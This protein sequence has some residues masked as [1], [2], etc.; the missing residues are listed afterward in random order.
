MAKVLRNLTD[1]P[2]LLTLSSGETLRLS[3]RQV[4]ESFE[5]V[6]VSGSEKVDR[7][8]AAGVV[9]VDAPR[10]SSASSSS[11]PAS[12]PASKTASKPASKAANKPASKPAAKAKADAED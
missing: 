2:V 1:R 6:E 12:K 3:P 7:L 9:A 8:V 5:D 11:K 4:S 10:R